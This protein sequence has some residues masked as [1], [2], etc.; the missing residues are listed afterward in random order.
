MK[1]LYLLILLFCSIISFGQT[2]AVSKKIQTLNSKSQQFKT[3]DLFSL[4]LDSRKA[5][6]YFTSATDVTVLDLNQNQLNR[7]MNDAPAYLEISVPYQNQ[8]VDVQ[9]Y[10]QGVVTESFIAKDEKGNILDYQL[11]EYYRGVIKGDYESLVAVSFFDGDV[12]GVISSHELGNIMLGKSTDQQDFISYSDKNLLG[13]NPFMCGADGLESGIEHAVPSFDP[14]MMSTTLTDNCVKIYYEVAYR[15]YQLRQSN[16]QNTLNWLTGIQ[17]NIGT[18]Y[19][20]D[21]INMA[22]NEVRIWTIPDP[23]DGTYQGFPNPWTSNLYQFRDTVTDFNGDL[24]HLVNSTTGNKTSVAFLNTLCTNSNYAYS[25]AEMA[26]QQ[27]PT[28]SW[29]IMAMTHEMG[30]S[31][32]S[33]HTHAC[34]WNGNNTA[35]DGCGPA[36]GANE[37][38]NAPLP[39]DGG[40]I[41]SYC[42]L[43]PSVGINFL[44][45]FGEQPGALIRNTID[46]RPCLGTD[47]ITSEA[48][49]T[50]AISAFS[51]SDLGGGNYQGQI[52]DATSAQWKYQAVP[53]GGELDDSQWQTIDSKTFTVAGI[54]GNQYYE[55]YVVNVCQDG[56][57]GGMKK[58]LILNGDFCEG[59]LFTDTGG[60]NGPYS[61][62]ETIIKTFY[63]QTSTAKVALS[64]ARIGLRTDED[65]MY[66]YNGDTTDEALLFEGGTLTANNNPGPSF[67]STHSTGAITVKFVSTDA[68]PAYGWEATVDCGLMSVEENDLNSGVKAYPNPASS[69]LNIDSQKEITSVRLN[70][71]SGKTIISKKANSLKEK[72]NIEHLQKGVYILTVEMKGQIVT[73]KIIKN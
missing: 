13:E 48:N 65:Y 9:L 58:S 32:G 37:G 33:P 51:V 31:L 27:V 43:I 57:E 70:D 40:T 53:F 44:N 39:T 67:T 29:T 45:G 55:I 17:N 28:Y 52:T 21:N 68:P 11:G 59:T 60:I 19:A 56:T 30:H 26:Y 25:N 22:I 16:I 36:G 71:I 8:T 34:A 15:P 24:A 6:K 10:K 46:S 41:M 66:V 7:L 12:M 4:D 63:P 20:N 49:C 18:L 42:H 14:E 54:T 35:I 47:C 2:H 5:A 64:F 38:C 1:K 72:L 69:V 73:K 3:Y 23:Y 50:Y 61:K 62:N